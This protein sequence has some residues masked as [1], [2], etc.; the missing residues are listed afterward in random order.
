MV[1]GP[2]PRVI[3]VLLNYNGWRT[4]IECLES[5]LR[6]DYPDLRALVVDN[7]STDGS[8]DQI[9]EW[10]RG[11]VAAPLPPSSLA[12][13]GSPPVPKPIH[14]AEWSC[15]DLEAQAPLDWTGAPIGLVESGRNLG[16][17]A[18]NNIALRYIERHER[19]SLVLLLNNDTVI[20]PS[21]ISAMVAAAMEST[22]ELT[23]V[24]ATILQYH[25]PDRVETFGG[26]TVRIWHGCSDMIGWGSPR[27]APRP[28]VRM[29]YVSGCC[30]MMSH[31]TLACV[32]LLDERFFI[33]NE[34]AD[35]GVR[36]RAAGVRLTYSANAE[37]WHKGSA[38]TVPKTEF[39]DYHNAKS[40]L[41]FARK[42]RPGLF[43]IAFL[44]LTT[45]FVLLKV[46]RGEWAR[47]GA[48]RSAMSDFFFERRAF[49]TRSRP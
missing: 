45:R 23:A 37:V 6:S 4:T 28:D 11:H 35:W 5:V 42:H 17:S 46:M 49:P 12:A 19:G 24:G 14:L 26:N 43:P 39:H 47:L 33:Y 31:E 10:A 9:R 13:L 22:N 25:A 1:T 18:G 48:V 32:G 16:F 8:R 29:S 7:G 36:A 21:A 40:L 2:A 34:D 44:Y 20:A 15:A 3:V 30:L 27:H 38:T 41:H